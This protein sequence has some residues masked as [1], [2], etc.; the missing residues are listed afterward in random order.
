MDRLHSYSD[1][2]TFF[3]SASG[4]QYFSEIYGE[5]TELLDDRIRAFQSL[6]SSFEKTYGAQKP[7]F[8]VRIPARINLMGVHVEHR[9][10]YVNYMTIGKETLIAVAPRTD[11]EIHFSNIQN[12]FAPFSFSIAAEFP[13]SKRGNWLTYIDQVSVQRGNWENYIRAASFYLQ[14][15]CAKPLRGM[16]V[17]VSGNIPLAAGLSSSSTLVVGTIEAMDY[18]NQLNLSQSDKTIMA[19]E[20]E[21]YVGTRGGAGDHAAM[22]FGKRN[23]IAHLQ[24]FPLKAEMIPFPENMRVVACN[25]MVPAEKSAGARD[26][27]NERVVTYEIA[28]MLL[29]Q[30]YPAFKN[31]VHLRDWNSTDL[32]IEPA[33]LYRMLKSLPISLTREQLSKQLPEKHKRLATLFS[34]HREPENGYQVRAVCMFGLGECARSE[35]AGELLK[36]GNIEEFGRLMYVSHDGDRVAIS[37]DQNQMH[38]FQKDFSDR[39]FDKLIR[40]AGNGE[41]EAA[42]EMQPGG[43]NCSTEEMDLLVDVVRNVDGVV[44]A[45][46]TGAGL[47]GMVLVLVKREHVDELLKV[48]KRKYYEPRGLPLGA[49]TCISVD[50]VS[51]L[52]IP[53]HRAE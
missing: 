30:K 32:K 4:K 8:I 28:F 16:E 36:S 49:E 2:R 48:L 7:F 10:G 5:Q 45:G 21:W 25:S 50:G 14:N 47:G 17:V 52:D 34:T 27:F 9:G 1:W 44:G 38:P 41:A 42:M 23:A 31:V 33:E 12:R 35:R 18:I 22:F 39:Y 29:A 46:L 43:Y 3:N 13:E 53:R 6:V 20:A 11:D 26:I 51:M 15:S 40:D 24:F 37:N 19:G